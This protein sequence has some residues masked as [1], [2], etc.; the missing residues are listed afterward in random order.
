MWDPYVVLVF[1]AL[2][3]V[4]AHEA[5]SKTAASRWDVALALLAAG[6]PA[7]LRPDAVA[8]RWRCRLAP[9]KSPQLA[10]L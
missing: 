2:N 3:L 7:H 10:V 8:A 4:S 6:A 1:G 5:A 9:R